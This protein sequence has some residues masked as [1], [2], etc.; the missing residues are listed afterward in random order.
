MKGE[1]MHSDV[2]D[3]FSAIGQSVRIDPALFPYRAFHFE[4]ISSLQLWVHCWGQNRFGRGTPLSKFKASVDSVDSIKILHFHFLSKIFSIQL[5]S[6]LLFAQFHHRSLWSS[7][8][9]NQPASRQEA[10]S[11]FDKWTAIFEQRNGPFRY[12][13]GGCRRLWEAEV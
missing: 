10:K 7:N 11:C 12:K 3:G 5:F 1:N 8:W 13:R 9:A 2:A 4:D 6:S